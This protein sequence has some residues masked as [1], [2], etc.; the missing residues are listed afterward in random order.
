M[1]TINGTTAGGLSSNAITPIT[2]EENTLF[3]DNQQ[4]NA[5]DTI[6]DFLQPGSSPVKGH[7]PVE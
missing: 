3:N 6:Q 2:S 1:S 4:N 5:S 7:P